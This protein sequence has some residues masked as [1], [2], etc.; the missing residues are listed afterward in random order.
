MGHS[1]PGSGTET[2]PFCIAG[3]ADLRSVIRRYQQGSGLRLGVLAQKQCSKIGLARQDVGGRD[4]PGHDG[5]LLIFKTL[6]L[7]TRAAF[8]SGSWAIQPCAT[9]PLPLRQ[10]EPAEH[11]HQPRRL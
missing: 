6:G 10:I 11:Q 5:N 3:S 4:K 1:A 7:K 2:V 9:L 8:S